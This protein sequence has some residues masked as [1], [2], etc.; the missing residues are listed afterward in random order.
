M[1]HASFRNIYSVFQGIT[2][3]NIIHS[4]KSIIDPKKGSVILPAFTYCFRKTDKSNEIFDRVNSP[5]KVGYISEVFR[6]ST[7]IIRT[8]SPTHSFSIW[9]SITENI[10]MNNNPESPLG[11]NSVLEWMS[12][13]DK[14]YVLMLGTDFTALTFGH[15]LEIITKVP[16]YN[17]SPWDYMKVESIGESNE[18]TIKLIEVPGCAK[19]FITFEKYLIENKVLKPQYFNKLRILYI[20]IDELIKAGKE[21]FRN[22]YSMLLCDKG[23]CKACDSRRQYFS[24]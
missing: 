8:S 22:N 2:A 3:D 18:D 13:K 10:S 6:N 4:I 19:S 15:Y 16:W 1:V 23:T 17:F 9:G 21:F 11:K 5:S 7:D 20:K 14:T 24:L 12:E